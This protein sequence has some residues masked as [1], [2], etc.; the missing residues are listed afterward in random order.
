MDKCL[1]AARRFMG[2]NRFSLPGREY[3]GERPCLAWPDFLKHLSRKG[4]LSDSLF[5]LRGPVRPGKM[6]AVAKTPPTK[7][8][9]R[10]CAVCGGTE[11]HFLRDSEELVC[12]DCFQS[13]RS[14]SEN[15]VID[16]KV[17]P[18]IFRFWIGETPPPHGGGA[19]PPVPDTL[20]NIRITI[21]KM[22]QVT[23]PGGTCD[24]DFCRG[25]KEDQS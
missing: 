18:G 24:C 23:F 20:R 25:A 16:P 3:H 11:R 7:K 21:Q 8:P 1:E 14:S 22:H 4:Y 10:T 12:F 19:F 9:L 5:N 15:L 2:L 13:S 17:Y 6:A